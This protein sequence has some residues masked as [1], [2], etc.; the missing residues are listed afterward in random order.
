[1]DFWQQKKYFPTLEVS[2]KMIFLSQFLRNGKGG[3][4]QSYEKSKNDKII[5]SLAWNIMFTNN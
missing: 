2:K 5:F 1:M 4:F 3:V